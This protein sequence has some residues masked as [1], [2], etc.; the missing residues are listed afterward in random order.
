MRNIKHK[1][2][3]YKNLVK[4]EKIT[5]GKAMSDIKGMTNSLEK[6]PNTRKVVKE[7]K[8]MIKDAGFAWWD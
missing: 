5:K 2:E 3:I 8:D 7:I 1:T 4:E 6:H